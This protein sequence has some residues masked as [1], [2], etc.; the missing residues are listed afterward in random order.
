[1]VV[2]L[3]IESRIKDKAVIDFICEYQ[4]RLKPYFNL[5]IIEAG[6]GGK[7]FKKLTK[8]VLASEIIIGLDAKGTKFNSEGFAEWFLLKR[9]LSKNIT[10]VI[11]ESTG[12]SSSARKVIKEYISLSDMTFSYRVGL[13]VIAEQIYRAMTIITG[14]PYHK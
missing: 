11:G 4:K 10:F 6:E 1:M 3:V 8:Q 7:F 9:D 12:I 2:K 13:M 5:E 14:H